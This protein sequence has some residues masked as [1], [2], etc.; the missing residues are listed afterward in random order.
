[1]FF[2]PLAGLTLFLLILASSCSYATVANE[3]AT[4]IWLIQ[5]KSVGGPVVYEC[6]DTCGKDFRP[7]C[8]Q[9]LNV[10]AVS[11]VRENREKKTNHLQN[12]LADD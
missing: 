6:C 7:K 5:T 11:V 12:E 8:W 4:R 9:A 3:D 10:D 1:M 2:L